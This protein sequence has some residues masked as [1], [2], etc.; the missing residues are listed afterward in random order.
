MKGIG[1]RAAYITSWMSIVLIYTCALTQFGIQLIRNFNPA[2]AMIM[3]TLMIYGG[4]SCKLKEHTV[5]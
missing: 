3:Y 4:K 5:W 2:V 1:S